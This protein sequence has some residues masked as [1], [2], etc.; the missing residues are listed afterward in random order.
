MFAFFVVITK[1]AYRIIVFKFLLHLYKSV[2]CKRMYV[3]LINN[4]C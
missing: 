4:L 3:T 1:Y 2:I